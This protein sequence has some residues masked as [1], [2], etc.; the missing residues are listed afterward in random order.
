MD[1]LSDVELAAQI[2][3]L[4]TL[5]EEWRKEAQDE[6]F[7][8]AQLFGWCPQAEI[9]NGRYAMF[10]FVVGLATESITGQSVPQQI[11]TLLEVVGIL[12]PS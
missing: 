9:L 12:P 11:V 5:A 4:D 2:T 3:T 7:N 8:N 6:A 1:E 10:F